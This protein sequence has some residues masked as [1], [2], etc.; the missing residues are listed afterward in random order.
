MQKL[1]HILALV[2][3]FSLLSLVIQLNLYDDREVGNHQEN[4]QIKAEETKCMD[5]HSNLVEKKVAHNPATESCQTCH[6]INIKEH[7]E[8][9]T[10][11]LMLV[12]KVPELCFN[13][14]DGLKSE[15]DTIKNIHG[16]LKEKKGCINCHS[17][18]SSTEKK[19]LVSEERE[20]CL[21]CHDQ[22]VTANGKKVRNIKKLLATSKVIHPPL[23]SDGCVVCHQPHGSSNNY[24]LYGKFPVGNYSPAKRENFSFCWD[25]HDSDIFGVAVNDTKT[26]FRDGNRNLHY[27]HRMGK[28]GRSCIVCHNV[29]ASKNEHLIEDRVKFGVWEMPIRYT[30]T[31]NGGS[32]FPGCHSERSYSR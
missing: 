22:D 10:L 16:A 31:K 5:C 24:L 26:N 11:G 13:C 1:L 3:F 14:H 15:L 32:C 8:N 20:L 21:S 9:G 17:P 30:P 27:L 2:P 23:K 19:L 18:H 6:D 4:Y 12:E 7:S 28:N 25:C 29:H